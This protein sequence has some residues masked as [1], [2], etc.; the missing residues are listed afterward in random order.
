MLELYRRALRIRREHPALGDGTLQWLDSP[1]GALA[2]A[3]D[4]AFICVVNL[5]GD[6]VAA[7]EGARLLLCSAELT[8]DGALPANTAAWFEH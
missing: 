5:T 3:R 1:D 8:A 2:F 4:P 6:P 7:P